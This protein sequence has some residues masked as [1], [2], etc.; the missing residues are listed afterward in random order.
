M[1]V[2]K[3]NNNNNIND[4]RDHNIAIN[5]DDIRDNSRNY[6]KSKEA[7]IV[8]TIFETIGKTKS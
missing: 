6:K 8:E 1:G 7:T 3:N 2:I 5:I 4:R